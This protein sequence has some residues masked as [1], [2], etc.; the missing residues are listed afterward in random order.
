[1]LFSLQT[2][3]RALMEN[4]NLIWTSTRRSIWWTQH[5]VCL[6]IHLLTNRR[7]MLCYFSCT[8]NVFALEGE[9]NGAR[10]DFLVLS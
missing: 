5:R 2:I 7:L 6:L 10:I 8:C 3:M 9:K 1:M 4:T